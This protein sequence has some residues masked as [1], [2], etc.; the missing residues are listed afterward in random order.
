MKKEL[1]FYLFCFFALAVCAVWAILKYTSK[2]PDS[3]TNI[4]AT[5]YPVYIISLNIADGI[6]NIE[7]LTSN[8]TGCLHDFVL[9]SRDMKKI[10]NSSV[11]ILNSKIDSFEKEISKKFPNKKIIDSSSGIKIHKKNTH[12]WLSVSN[13][14]IQI[15][16]ILN[17][18]CKIFPEHEHKF[19]ENAENY[20]K[21]IEDLKNNGHNLLDNFSGNDVVTINSSLYYLT[22]EFNFNSV[23]LTKHHNENFSAHDVKKSI[24]T[25]NKYKA[26]FILTTSSESDKKLAEMISREVDIKVIELSLIA[27]SNS[28]KID[29]N[30]YIN[31]MIQN[32]KVLHQNLLGL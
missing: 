15:K 13:Y 21:K 7:N 26:K 9:Q 16:N 31:E 18:L 2:L 3:K 10:E 30:S 4:I 19:K 11:L 8:H 27:S 14:I 12:I 17:E 5:S 25:L 23:T 29:K 32:F 22:N 6:L 1:I 24:K 28:K 20:I